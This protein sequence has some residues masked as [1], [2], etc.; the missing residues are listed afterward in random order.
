MAHDISKTS[1]RNVLD[2]RR[3]PYWQRLETGMYIGFRKLEAGAGTWIARRRNDEGSQE[4]RA[5][6]TV[7]AYDDAV[8]LA[9]EWFAARDAG[10][11]RQGMTVKE[12]CEHYVKHLRIHKS[13]ASAADAEGRFRRLV[14]DAK[15][16]KVDLAKLRTSDLKAWIANQLDIDEEEDDEEDLRRAKDSANRNL[17]SLKAALNLAL[18][19]RLVAHDAGWKTVVPFKGVGR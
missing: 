17:A 12:A 1:V 8:K 5:L 19:D 15:I 11:S 4:Y 7:A 6:G 18:H 10:V 9:R 13:A 3:E 14:N 16:G 2:P